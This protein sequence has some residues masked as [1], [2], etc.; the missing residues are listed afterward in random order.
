MVWAMLAC[1]CR[2]VL[3][4]SA[5]LP[6]QAAWIVREAL[7]NPNPPKW[8]G[9]LLTSQTAEWSG[10]PRLQKHCHTPTSLVGKMDGML[11]MTHPQIERGTGYCTEEKEQPRRLEVRIAGIRLSNNS[12]DSPMA[13][14]WAR[15]NALLPRGVPRTRIPRSDSGAA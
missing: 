7:R 12:W 13:W 1:L 9:R 8:S 15:T 14:S 5:Q 4:Q 10:W 3:K 2:I 11:G 6:Q